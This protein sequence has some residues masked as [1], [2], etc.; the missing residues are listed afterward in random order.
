MM[1]VSLLLSLLGGVL[2]LVLR[3]SITSLAERTVDGA[4]LETDLGGDD[5]R[6]L[7]DRDRRRM[8]SSSMTDDCPPPPPNPIPMKHV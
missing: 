2:S 8:T 4:L 5:L 1:T 3:T 6:L 7:T